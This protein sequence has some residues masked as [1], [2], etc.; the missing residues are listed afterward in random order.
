M[1]KL[2]VAAFRPGQIPA[3]VLQGFN[4]LLDFHVRIISWF[5][6]ER[7]TPNNGM[8][9]TADTLPVI[10]LQSRG[11]AGDAGRYAAYA[12]VVEYRQ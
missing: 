12:D 7:K 6:R 5:A 2:A 9:P 11:A 3:V 1:L 4:D 8:Y 10:F